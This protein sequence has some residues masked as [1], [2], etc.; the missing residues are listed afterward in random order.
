VQLLSVNVAH[1][2]KVT[3]RGRTYSTA[4]FKQPVTGRAAVRRLNI[5]GDSQGNPRTHGGPDMAIYVFGHENCAQWEREYGAQLPYG[6][7]GENLTVTGMDEAEVAVGDIFRIGSTRLQV[8]EPRT[9]CHKLAMKFEDDDLPRRFA[10]TGHV[11]FYCRVLTEGDI[12]A[13]DAIIRETQDPARLTIAEVLALWA[14]KG[15]EATRLERA[16]GVAALSATWRARFEA[17]LESLAAAAL[18]AADLKTGG[19]AAAASVTDDDRLEWSHERLT[20]V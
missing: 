20:W 3:Y 16:L 2:R 6:A 19:S 7:F 11:G 15:A 4:I 18:G 14:D 5:D 12:G 9:P 8:T 17:R 13:G 10:A 1:P